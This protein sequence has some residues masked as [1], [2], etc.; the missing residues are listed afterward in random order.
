MKITE[1]I[2]KEISGLKNFEIF[3]IL[4]L[5]IA[6]ATNT[7]LLKDNTIAAVSAT[8]GILYTFLAGKGKASCY[9]FG[10]CGSGCYSWLSFQNALWG[11]LILYLCYYIPSQIFGFFSWKKHLK[12]NAQEIIK[13]QLSVKQKIVIFVIGLLGS[14]VCSYILYLTKDSNPIIDG[15]TTFLSIIG[16]YLTVKR[17]IE[18]W[19]IWFIVNTL[20]FIMW[21]NI[22]L[23]GQKVY[24]TLLMWFVY[25]MLAIYFYRE[26]RKEITNKELINE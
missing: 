11:N 14:I 13:T 1:V 19:I 20:S 23:S 17:C 24:S 7:L 12:S 9:L 21:L 8:C 6:I 5:I 10:I 25:V 15:I 26:W 22:I 18:Q 4:I 2:K 16:M 3:I